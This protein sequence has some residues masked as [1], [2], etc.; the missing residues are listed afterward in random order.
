[1][2]L[3]VS[4]LLLLFS[5]VTVQATTPLKIGTL[6]I[7]D[8]VP[9]YVAEAQGLYAQQGVQVELIPFLSA[10]E[11]DSALTAGAIDGAIDDPVGAILLD[12]GRNLIRITSLCLGATPAE[13]IFAIMAAPK[14]GFTTVEDLKNVEIGVSSSTIIEYVTD[15]MLEAQGFEKKE[16]KKIE[17]K[18]MPIRLQMLLANAIQ[19]ATLPEPLASVAESKGAI[20]LLTDA[21]T[22]K[23]LS[24]TVIVMRKQVLDQRKEDVV[25]FF[26][27]YAKAVE[28][29]N[30]DP[31]QFRPLFVEK[32]RIPPKIAANYPIPHYPAPTPF[33]RELYTPVIDWMVGKGLVKPLAYEQ[34]VSTDFF[35]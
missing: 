3:F 24:Q 5:A 1:M 35:H 34:L 15:R 13:G 18:K 19:A 9:F 11:R 16:I 22:G 14:S 25:R 17:I 27:A 30:N 12:Q 4:L 33:S 32:G 31:E 8:V 26:A 2:K 7:E 20:K 10:L 29:I 23:S 28:M 6:L 21:Q